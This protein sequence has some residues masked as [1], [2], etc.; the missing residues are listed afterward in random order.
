MNELDEY[1]ERYKD[2]CF[3]DIK[4]ELLTNRKMDINSIILITDILDGLYNYI[5]YKIKNFERNLILK[6]LEN[7]KNSNYS[8]SFKKFKRLESLISRRC[9]HYTNKQWDCWRIYKESDDKSFKEKHFYYE[10]KVNSLADIKDKLLNRTDWK[11]FENSEYKKINK[12]DFKSYN[13]SEN[14]L[15]FEMKEPFIIKEANNI[16]NMIKKI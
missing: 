7:S 2:K 9:R 1:L 13:F 6:E 14:F 12:L 8:K 10:T 4:S 16:S 15:S 5:T 11:I 3:N